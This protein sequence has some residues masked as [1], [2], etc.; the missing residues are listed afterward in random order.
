MQT[1]TLLLPPTRYVIRLHGAALTADCYGPSEAAAPGAAE[2]EQIGALAADAPT[3]TAMLVAGPARQ[4]VSWRVGTWHQPDPLTLRIALSAIDLPLTA[5]VTFAIDSATGLLSRHTT[6]RHR[7]IGPDVDVTATLA[8]W[9]GIH[10]PVDHMRYLAGAWAQET[11]LRHGHGDMPLRLES[12]VGKTGFDF[13]PYTALRAGASTYL[14][15]IFWSGN[16]ALEVVPYVGGAVLSG[17]LNNWRFRCRLNAAASNLPLP[18]VLFGRFD[19]DLNTAT[20]RLHDY[21]RARRPDP[22]RAIPV[23]FNSWYPYLGEPTAHAMLPLVPLAKRLGCEAFV[24]DAGWYKTDDGES[25]G[26]WMARTGDWQTSRERFPEGLREVSARC[27]E[28]GLQFGLWFEPE[29]IGSLSAIRRDHPEWLHHI[30][31]RPPTAHERAILNLGVPAARRHAFERV[32]RI[33]SAVGVD[34]MKWDFNADL[35]VGGWAP[36]LPEALTDQDPLVAHY[37]GLYRLQDAIRRWFPNLILEMC[38][39]GG[40]RMDGELLSHAHVNWISDQP[41][42]LR[43]LAIHVGSQLAHPAVVCNDWLIEWP[44]GSIAGYDDQ[45]AG[46]LDERG[47]FPFR[48]RV[49]ML[50]SFGISARI[51]RWPEADLAT[52][53]AHIALYR[54][55][56]RPIIHE[57]DQYLLTEAPPGDGNGSWVA[58]WYAAKDGLSGVLFAFRLLSPEASRVFP[59]PGLL[60]D[61]RYR[62]NF[63]SGPAPQIAGDALATGLII[64]VPG[65]FQ[66]ELCFIESY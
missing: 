54:Q 46:G 7:G 30:D 14:C 44:P 39:S 9:F 12:R 51:D 24:V 3:E 37:E 58:I 36:G 34:W 55:K 50:G 29:V 48:L 35:G 43:K 62:A 63:S 52:A 49:A 1:W 45:D 18:T 28:H 33:L 41:G 5:D 38:A 59:L 56:L 4:P 17:G 60:P 22:D 53:A 21:R 26:D 27:R 8:F 64:T 40:G 15:Q 2:A 19:G 65:P 13:Q 47:D 42:P 10:E 16:W 6:I 23:Q 66:S 25:D 57:G 20:Q 61:R 11:Q 31:G 32:T